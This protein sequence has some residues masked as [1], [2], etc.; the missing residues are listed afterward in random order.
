MI[1]F[2]PGL[3]LLRRC[4]V[5]DLGCIPLQGLAHLATEACMDVIAATT[6]PQQ[7]H[8]CA[9][10]WTLEDP[11]HRANNPLNRRC[12]WSARNAAALMPFISHSAHTSH[13]VAPTD[14]WHLPCCWCPPTLWQE[15]LR[16]HEWFSKLSKMVLI[17]RRSDKYTITPTAGPQPCAQYFCDVMHCAPPMVC[18]H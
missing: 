2:L 12:E 6:Q 18:S 1:C 11:P 9:D 4:S 5:R 15:L 8:T 16:A 7:Q 17:T 3:A 10:P 14:L 13:N